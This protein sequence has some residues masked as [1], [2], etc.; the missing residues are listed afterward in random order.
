MVDDENLNP[1]LGEDNDR[2]SDV[3]HVNFS[4]K[5]SSRFTPGDAA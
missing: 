4:V 3:L 5:Q 1:R 2:D